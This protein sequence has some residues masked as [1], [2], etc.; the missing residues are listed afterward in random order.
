MKINIALP[1]SFYFSG[2][3]P[4]K[5]WKYIILTKEKTKE[6]FFPFPS[7]IITFIPVALIHPLLTF[8]SKEQTKKYFT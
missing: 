7:I 2:F 6:N 4:Q 8:N 5:K 3:F 1:F